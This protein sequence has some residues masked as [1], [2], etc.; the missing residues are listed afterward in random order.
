MARWP[1]QQR[2]AQLLMVGVD[3]GAFAEAKEVVHQFGVGG[4]FIGG[5]AV[6]LISNGSLLDLASPSPVRP[7]VA[8]DEEG[9]RVQRIDRLVESIPSARRMAAT[10]RRDNVLRTLVRRVDARS[11]S[12]AACN[13]AQRRADRSA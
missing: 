2:L 13:A 9:G 12:C 7:L 3:T 1:L 10:L 4:V 11:A 8:V 6:D 5:D